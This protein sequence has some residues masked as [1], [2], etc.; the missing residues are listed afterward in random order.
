MK[1]GAF[2]TSLAVADLAASKAFY[3][4]LGFL[5][6]GGNADEGWLILRNEQTTIGLFHGMFDA[7]ILTFNPGLDAEAMAAK[8]S[9]TDIRDLQTV[10]RERGIEPED[11]GI[12]PEGTA[13]AHLRL[14]DPDGNHIL[15]DQF[16]P[17]PA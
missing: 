1:L 8:E 6:V 4:A 7:N 16:F 10:L 3:E 15:L 11:G 12:D 5:E 9:F 2:S 17:R 13:P 14:V